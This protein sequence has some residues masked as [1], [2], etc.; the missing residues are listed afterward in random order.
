MDLGDVL[1]VNRWRL[2]WD[3]LVRGGFFAS[4]CTVTTVYSIGIILNKTVQI[5][6][7]LIAFLMTLII[8]FYNFIGELKE[9]MRDNLQ[10]MQKIEKNKRIYLIFLILLVIF[11]ITLI[12][13][14]ANYTSKIFALFF[15]TLGILYTVFLKKIT[16]K[17]IGFKDFFVVISW[18]LL[19]PFFVIYH[20]YNFTVAV[21]I[22]M[23]F[24][25]TRDIVNATYSD[26]KDIDVDKKNHL[27][28]I[29]NVLGKDKLIM[30]LHFIGM[31]GVIILIFA[32]FKEFFP[33]YALVLIIPI[34]ISSISIEYAKKTSNF[35]TLF[36]DSESNFWLLFLLGAKYLW[37]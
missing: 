25:M 36:L 20:S 26:I 4:I 2:A 29:A 11:L 1:Y 34:I 14:Y 3:E 19:T 22:L 23:L 27:Q 21:F 18:N 31:L 16:Q 5:D 7:V 15:L 24:I 10:E 33:R 6:F 17:V 37:T 32:V 12:I 8:Y 35:T 28:T 9:D 13:L 30:I